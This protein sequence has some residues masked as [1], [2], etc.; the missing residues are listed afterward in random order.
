MPRYRLFGCVIDSDLELA[1]MPLAG[2]ASVDLEIRRLERAPLPIAPSPI[3]ES[4]IRMS[5]G[6]SAATFARLGEVDVLRL[7]DEV[8]LRL[9]AHRIEWFP[10]GAQA[11]A[12]LE[13][14][15]PGSVLALWLERRGLLCLHAAAFER[16]GRAVAMLGTNGAGKSSL[17][18]ALLAA[19][20]Q[21]LTEDVLVLEPTATGARVRPSHPR[22]RLWAEPLERLLGLEAE[23]LPRAHPE[24]D[25][26]SLDLRSVGSGG[27]CAESRPLAELWL[28]ERG[29]AESAIEAVPVPAREAVVELIRHS[30]SPELARAAGLE[31]AR[32]EGLA[33]IAAQVPVARL[34]YPSGLDRLPAVGAWLRGARR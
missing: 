26:R 2:E 1:G 13:V 5:D 6:R 15:L 18:A 3:Y 34:H 9:F 29:D 11:E 10:L 24:L 30:F 16:D 20:A 22:M 23:G 32:W 19:G 12:L 8:E 17:A 28:L 21:L 25:K 4:R 33:R 27:F 14:H 31:L 7:A